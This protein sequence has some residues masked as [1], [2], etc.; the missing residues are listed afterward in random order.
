MT[1]RTAAA[2]MA[3]AAMLAFVVGCGKSSTQGTATPTTTDKAAATSAL[4]DPCTQVSADILNKLGVNKESKESGIGG[5]PQPGWKDC[6]WDYPPNHERSVTIW[7][8]IFSIDDLKKKT[9]NTDFQQVTV[10]GRAGWK[11]HQGSDKTQAACDLAFQAS[12]G[13]SYQISFYNL[14]PSLTTS[15]CDGAM[16]VAQ[17][18]VPIFP[19]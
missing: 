4:W 9:D 6:A 11:Y 7:S 17:V 18:V 8:S 3:T 15:P 5:V 2:V 12:S 14:E 1:R 10:G 13:G 19:K 16:S